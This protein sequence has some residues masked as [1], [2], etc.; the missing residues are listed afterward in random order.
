MCD[1]SDATKGCRDE[2][3]HRAGTWA[4]AVSVAGGTVT[5]TRFGRPEKIA[6]SAE[7][8]RAGATTRDTASGA[9]SCSLVIRSVRCAETQC[10][11]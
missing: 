1:Y 11:P 4:V 2:S 10:R 7:Q 8:Q 6:E 3:K 5:S 9:R